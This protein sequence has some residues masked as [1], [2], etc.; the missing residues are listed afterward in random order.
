MSDLYETISQAIADG[1]SCSQVQMKAVGGAVCARQGTELPHQLVDAMDGLAGGLH[2]GLTCGSLSG[3]ACVMALA[4]LPREELKQ[5]CRELTDWFVQEYETTV[6][7][8]ILEKHGG[9]SACPGIMR[10]TALRCTEQLEDAG[11][12]P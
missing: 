2:C 9:R 11:I 7:E 3:A 5:Q 4:G 1:L 12:L 6:C 8:E 10:E